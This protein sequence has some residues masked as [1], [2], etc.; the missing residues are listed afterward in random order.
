[1]GIMAQEGGQR[2]ERELVSMDLHRAVCVNVVDLGS[3]LNTSY[4]KVK[5]RVRLTF[6]LADVRSEYDVDGEMKSLPRLMGKEYNLSLWET[7]DLR[8]DLQ[9]WRKKQFTKEELA[10]FDISVLVG[11]PCMLNVEHY[12]GRDGKTRAGIGSI[13]GLGAGMVA[14]APEGIPY[15]Y[16]IADHGREF[17]ESMPDF[18]KEKILASIEMAGAQA[19]APVAPPAQQAPPAAS[20]PP[21][22]PPGYAPPPTATGGYAE[23]AD[24]DDVPF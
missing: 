16:S 24:G 20:P 17:P 11:V 22:A 12:V 8:K 2:T 6:E 21:Q 3:H 5:P 14:P 7:A 4:N 19:P 15:F 9:S 18:I 10:G 1:M 13:I 23:D